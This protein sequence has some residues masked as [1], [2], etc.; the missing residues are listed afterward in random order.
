MT[1]DGFQLQQR[2]RKS[3]ALA[4]PDL[5][6]VY[7]QV[8]RRCAARRNRRPPPVLQARPR[9]VLPD[10]G[11]DGFAYCTSEPIL[12]RGTVVASRR[13]PAG[14]S[15]S[16][17]T[18]ATRCRP[19]PQFNPLYAP[20]KAKYKYGKLLPNVGFTYQLH[21]SDQ[22]LRQLRQG[23]LGAAHRQPLSRARRRR[24]AGR[25]QRVRPRRCATPRRDIQAQVA[26]GRSTTRTGSSPR[27]TR[28]S[29]SRS[30]ATSAR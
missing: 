21:R 28:I 23:L 20:F 5:R 7:R 10:P 2:D 8:L 16:S 6:P 19:T 1:A 13:R 30:T 17:S 25:D 22:R 24:E 14:R 4:E 11:R 27:S 26:A 15:R 18:R 3:I 29:A 9:H 12:A